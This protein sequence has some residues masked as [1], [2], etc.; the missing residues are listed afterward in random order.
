MGMAERGSVLPSL[1]VLAGPVL[2]SSPG[3]MPCG[4]KTYE[5]PLKSPPGDPASNFCFNAGTLS[6][7]ALCFRKWHYVGKM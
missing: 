3:R 5:K 7:K 4:A 6:R 2:I 1:I